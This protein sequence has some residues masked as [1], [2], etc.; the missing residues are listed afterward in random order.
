M[1]PFIDQLKREHKALRTT[2]EQVYQLGIGSTEAQDKLRGVRNLLVTHLASEDAK[3]YPA[4]E[5]LDDPQA[6]AAVAR[7]KDEMTAI[8][9]SAVEFLKKYENGGSGFQFARDFGHFMAVM[10]SRMGQE[11][12]AL[13][14]IYER[15][16]KS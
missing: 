4:L 7:M 5:A 1:N 11:E 8:T 12:S 3:L 16:V 9:A 10:S 13:Y 6:K 2:L 14:P 15:L